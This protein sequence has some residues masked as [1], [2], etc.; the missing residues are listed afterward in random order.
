MSKKNEGA[1]ETKYAK[2]R[3]PKGTRFRS[4]GGGSEVIST[5]KFVF[6]KDG[7]ISVWIDQ[8]FKF[9][10]K[11]KGRWAEVLEECSPV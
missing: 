9:L 4:A 3:Y 10:V 6:H 2:G 5:G 8:D 11:Y 7:D 1:N